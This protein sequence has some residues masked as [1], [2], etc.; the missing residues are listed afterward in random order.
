[1]Y[2]GQLILNE[3][4]RNKSAGCDIDDVKYACGLVGYNKTQSLLDILNADNRTTALKPE[5]IRMVANMLFDN[6]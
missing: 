5:E 1:V 2:N 4:N 3:V 6:K